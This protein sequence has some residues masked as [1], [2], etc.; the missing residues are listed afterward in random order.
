M[1]YEMLTSEKRGHVGLIVFDRP[2]A[3]NALNAAL[4]SELADALRE[5]ETDDS[6][7]AIVLTGSDKAFAAGADIKEMADL[8]YPQ[9]LKDDF[10]GRESIAL[11]SIRKPVVGAVSGYAPIRRRA[12]RRRSWRPRTLRPAHIRRRHRPQVCARSA[13]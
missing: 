8:R 7:G 5:F 11:Q 6:I 1:A 3:L 13:T 4:V 12:R 2:D 10:M 9:T